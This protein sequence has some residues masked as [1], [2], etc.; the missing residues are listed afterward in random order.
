MQFNIKNKMFY[1]EISADLLNLDH[2]VT[3]TPVSVF[4]RIQRD[5]TIVID[6]DISG[7][8][9]ID[10]IERKS[11]NYMINIRISDIFYS[12]KDF[13]N[14]RDE[15]IKK[16]IEIGINHFFIP[17]IDSKHHNR[18]FDLK[19][20][21]PNYIYLMMGLHP[22]YVKENFEEELAIVE[23]LL[24]KSKFHAIGE[25]GIDLFREKKYLVEQQRAFEKQIILAKS[26]NLPIVI[27]C[28]DAF[29]EIYEILLKNK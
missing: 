10:A 14:D 27:H 1:F 19:K 22:N 4:P 13:D 23:D 6:D 11:F 2:S 7:N 25:I 29:E 24:S 26:Y 15:V 5:L 17:S 18:M 3:Y 12:K 9:I 28:R 20:K 8:D 21:F 16:A